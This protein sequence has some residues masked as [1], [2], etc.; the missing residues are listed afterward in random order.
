MPV[1]IDMT[2]RKVVVFGGGVIGL[3]KAAYFAKEAEVV[4]VSREFVEGFAERGIR[5]ERAEIGEAAE[6]WIAW[7]DLVVVATDD[8]PLNSWLEERARG[9]GRPCNSADG[10]SSFLIPSVIERRNFIVAVSTLGRSPAM[11][12]HLRMYLDGLLGERHCRMI[13][14]QE[15]L[16]TAAKAALPDQ[17]A[18]ERFLGEVIAD[19][20][21][22]SALTADYGKA[23]EMAIKRMEGL[24]AGH[25]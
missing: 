7:A 2:S 10:V 6:R 9:R 18:R 15:D 8:P 16:R 12:K 3:R 24:G 4:A 25:N 21:I 5:T 20:A 14:L 22:W 11:T 13:D 19:E 23:K 17:R 1:L